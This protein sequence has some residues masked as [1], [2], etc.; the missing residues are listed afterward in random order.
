MYCRKTKDVY[1]LEGN[2][3]YGWD[4]LCEYDNRKDA[5]NDLKT[6]RENEIGYVHRII[7]RRVMID[8]GR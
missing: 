3:G 5:L 2:Y 7:K 1:V 6:Y 8:V 4:F